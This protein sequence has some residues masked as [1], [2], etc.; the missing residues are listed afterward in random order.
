[1]REYIDLTLLT[2]EGISSAAG[3]PIDEQV[4]LESLEIAMNNGLLFEVRRNGI[5]LSYATLKD[6]GSGTWFILIFITHP[7][8]RTKQVF[9]EL[10]SQISTHL[11]SVKARK[12]VS[13]VLRVNRL[14]LA[15]HRKLGFTVTRKADIGFEFTMDLDSSK[16]MHWKHWSKKF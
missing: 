15:F 4:Y 14:S 9:G 13:N 10:F 1:M 7:N 5:L 11:E 16:A 6:I 8:H 3:R 2:L 12:L